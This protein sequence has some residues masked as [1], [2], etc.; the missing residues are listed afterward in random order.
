MG[1][2]RRK[3]REERTSRKRRKGGRRRR[4]KE[5]QQVIS[6][7][8]KREKEIA[9]EGV[10]KKD[11]DLGL[12]TLPNGRK[13]MTDNIEETCTICLET[14]TIGDTIRLLPCLHKF[15]KD[16]VNS[17]LLICQSNFLREMLASH[18]ERCPSKTGLTSLGGA[19][20]RPKE[21]KLQCCNYL[22][23]NCSI[24][25]TG[26]AV[27]FTFT[28]PVLLLDQFTIP[29]F[30]R[31]DLPLGVLLRTKLNGSQANLKVRHPIHADKH[32]VAY[33]VS[34]YKLEEDS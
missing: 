21:E 25:S 9:E 11:G 19:W 20:V 13:T 29:K 4:I 5:E 14:P 3:V 27:F 28:F 30:V 10:E 22:T 34:M 18:L 31:R 1:K 32:I 7:E 33:V 6:G 23:G 12:R 17:S 2:K 26:G 24:G 15:H 16:V 8:E